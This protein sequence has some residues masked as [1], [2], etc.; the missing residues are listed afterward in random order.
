[1]SLHKYQFT[2]SHVYQ[3]IAGV[4][5]LQGKIKMFTQLS[6]DIFIL[7]T[8]F[9]SQPQHPSGT[10]RKMTEISNNIVCRLSTETRS[11]QRHNARHYY[12]GKNDAC[13]SAVAYF[14]AEKPHLHA[15]HWMCWYVCV[16]QPISIYIYVD[17]W[18]FVYEM[19]FS[20]AI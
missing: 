14:Q 12:S 6:A 11:S 15:L 20:S 7:Q 4:Y 10:L 16:Y 19:S 13:V 8:F 3:H 9:K 1:M 17:V 2:L 5:D 18:M